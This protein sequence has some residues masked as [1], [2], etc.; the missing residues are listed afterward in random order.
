ME[1]GRVVRLRPET[2][3]GATVINPGLLT[4]AERIQYEG[5]IRRE[6][7][8]AAILGLAKDGIAI[9]KIARRT[10]YS[11]GLV[12]NVLR[13]RRSDVFRSRFARTI[14]AGARRVMGCKSS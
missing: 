3:I 2:A 14:S 11:G 12:R 1:R 13:G 4:A 7:A 5:Y 6:E 8:N 10:G 9:K